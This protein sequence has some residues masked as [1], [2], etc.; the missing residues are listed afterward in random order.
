MLYGRVYFVCRQIRL[1]V[2]IAFALANWDFKGEAVSPKIEAISGWIE[3][4]AVGERVWEIINVLSVDENVFHLYCVYGLRIP[5][6]C[7]A[8]KLSNMSLLLRPSE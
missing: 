3:D 5:W 7:I 1:R 8:A 2:Q 4:A 6:M